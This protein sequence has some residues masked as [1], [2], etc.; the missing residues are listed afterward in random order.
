MTPPPGGGGVCDTLHVTRH[1]RGGS[2]LLTVR[3][4][5]ASAP[6]VARIR[7]NAN[8]GVEVHPSDLTF[9]GNQVFN[10]SRG[11]GWDQPQMLFDGPPTTGV[12]LDY[13]GSTYTAYKLGSSDTTCSDG[14][15]NRIYSYDLAEDGVDTSVG[16]YAIHAAMVDANNNLW[17]ASTSSQNVDTGPDGFVLAGLICST[18]AAAPFPGPPV[19]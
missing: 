4:P 14:L 8:N 19:E 1:S 13:L 17:G 7:E 10:N 15:P 2:G 16:V 6:S 18:L 11:F 3:R 9:V 5:R 12:P